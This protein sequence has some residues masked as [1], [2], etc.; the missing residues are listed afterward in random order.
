MISP[1]E[2]KVLSSFAERIPPDDPGAHNNLA[3]VYYNKGLYPEAIE[4]LEKALELNPN[5][6]LARNNLE[7]ILRKTGK[8]EERV[9]QLSLSIEKD[10]HDENKILELADTYV[11]LQKYSHAIVYYKKVLDANPDSY[12]AHFGFSNTLKFLGKY[13]DALEEMK[14]ALKIREAHEGYRMMGEIYLRKGVIDMS[15]KNLEEALKFDD[16]SAETYFL[17]GLALGEKGRTQDSIE[18]VKKA[19]SLNPALAREEGGLPIDI[20]SQRDQWEFLKEQLGIPKVSGDSYKIHYNM[21]MSYRNKGLFDEAEREFNECLKLKKGAP[22]V[23]FAIAEADIY[24]GKFEEATHN[25]QQALR[26]D[27]DAVKC[28]NA[29]G[30]VNIMQGQIGGALEWFE[31]VLV[32]DGNDSLALNNIAVAQYMLGDIDKALGNYEKSMA[33]GNVDAKFNLAMHYLKNDDYDKTLALLDYKS[34]DVDF[35]HGLVY[36]ERGEDKKA[37]DAFERVLEVVP[38]HAGAYYNMGFIATRLGKYEEGLVHIRKGMEIEPNYD[39][40]KYH[41]SLDP[42]I[43]EFGPYYIPRSHPVTDEVV[44]QVLAPQATTPDELLAE[45]ER[46]LGRNNPADA[47]KRVGEA[48][49]IDP[50]YY[51]AAL[52]KADILFNQGEVTEAIEL[53]QNKHQAQPDV[54]DIIAALAIMLKK[55]GRIEEARAKYQELADL[56]PENPQW[57]NEVAELAYSLGEEDD[58][59]E[60]YIRVY[61][62]DREN[63]GVNLKLLR[64]Y[65]NKKDYAS[66]E[67]F[68]DFLASERPEDYEYN[69]LAG[70]YWAEKH[71]YGRAKE[72]FD[73][74]IEVDASKPLPYYHRGLLSVQQGAFTDAC[75]SWK[76]ALLLS[77]PQDLA[78]KIR[79][80]LTLTIELSEIL[81]KEI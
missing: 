9:E 56:E 42:A 60:S 74:A 36:M 76:K 41:L 50:Q 45:A 51:K 2:Q 71:Q 72:H 8:L 79:H 20:E 65:I 14:Y 58:A 70:I 40:E 27:F 23:H 3:I 25:L 49:E 37:L 34:I 80:C 66:A 21:G 75:E 16:N 15:I 47:L 81:E 78:D 5:F 57:F 35:L 43:S 61:E 62:R 6:V 28:A 64:I 18:A 13:D 55:E 11:K 12:R 38:H 69:I 22:E 53:L 46:Y 10:P 52:L 67:P 33:A 44:E 7:I 30:V 54:V 17:L 63:V 48:L 32:Q 19:I 31:K 77:P 73:K 68:V 4:E 1:D 29:L 39:N 24:L 26:R 59:L